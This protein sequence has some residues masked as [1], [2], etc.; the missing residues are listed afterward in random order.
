MYYPLVTAI[1]TLYARPFSGSNIIGRWTEQ[2][3]PTEYRDLHEQ[4][5]LMRN[6]LIAHSDAETLVSVSSHSGN[7]V[8]IRRTGDHL[9]I[10]TFQV[11]PELTLVARTRDL[12]TALISRIGTQLETLWENRKREFPNEPGEYLV[13]PKL[14]GFV[15]VSSSLLFPP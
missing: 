6:Q 9:E 4:M 8:R 14:N 15:P 11:K 13:D 2:I 12:A 3:V 1:Y 7:N 10:G 5:M